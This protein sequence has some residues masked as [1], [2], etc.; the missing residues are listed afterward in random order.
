[1]ASSALQNNQSLAPGDHVM[2]AGLASQVFTLLVFMCLGLDFG[3]RVRRR[4]KNQGDAALALDPRLVAI[5]NSWAFRGFIAAL[6][7]ATI[8]VF[9]RCAYRVAELNQGWNGPVT[10][11]QGLFV[12][13]EGVLMVFVVMA[14][15]IMHPALCMGVAMGDM[16]TNKAAKKKKVSGPTR[17]VADEDQAGAANSMEIQKTNGGLSGSDEGVESIIREK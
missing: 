12:G 14:L 5:R 7:S 2:T 9:W 6:A 16:E 8:A 11:K 15:C 13:F 3:L 1:M 4:K 17:L 10:Y